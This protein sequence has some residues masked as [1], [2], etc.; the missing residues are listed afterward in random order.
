MNYE[1]WII[2]IIIIVGLKDLGTPAYFIL[3]PWPMPRR[4][5]C[6]R[7]NKENPDCQDILPRTTMSSADWNHG[8]VKC[9]AAR[10][11]LLEH[12]KGSSECS[13]LCH[14]RGCHLRIKYPQLTFWPYWCGRDPWTVLSRSQQLTGRQ[15]EWLM[16]HALKYR[17]GW[18]ISVGGGWP[19]REIYRT[20]EI[21]HRGCGG[22]AL[23]VSQ[24]R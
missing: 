24:T 11:S 6:P 5:K 20:Q 10:G 9:H 8:G 21:P 23:L 4:K 7:T 3:G 13:G 1:L 14:R 16:E 18:L 15:K 22:R 17:H 19:K 12:P 2:I